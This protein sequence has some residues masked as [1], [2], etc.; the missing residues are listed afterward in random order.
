MS[1]ENAKIGKK[2]GHKTESLK[3]SFKPDVSHRT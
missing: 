3:I 1:S 2:M